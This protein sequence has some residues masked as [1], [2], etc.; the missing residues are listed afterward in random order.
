MLCHIL[1]SFT[2]DENNIKDLEYIRILGFSKKGQE[3]LN[4]IKNDI[5]TP[6]L[7]KY[8]TKKY[9]TLNIE[10]RVSQIYSEVYEDILKE[11]L[12]NKPIKKDE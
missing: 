9:K 7:N 11:E 8:D 10:Y 5:E 6:I 3:Y 12:S 4:K 2:K 1:C